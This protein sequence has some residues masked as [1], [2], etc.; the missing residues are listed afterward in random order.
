M[1][2]EMSM[3]AMEIERF[4]Q[5]L[6]KRREEIL[7]ASNHNLEAARE[8]GTDG[9]SDIADEGSVSYNRMVLVSLSEAEKKHV[10]EIDEALFRIKNGTYGTCQSC[11]D[12]VGEKRLG[13]KPEAPLCIKCQNG[14][15]GKR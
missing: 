11:G 4:R 8:F 6:L 10:V 5:V 12:P 2:K 9:V 15:E 7:N 1:L 3:D 13:V 14:A